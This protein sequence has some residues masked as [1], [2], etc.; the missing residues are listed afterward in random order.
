[1]GHVIKFIDKGVKLVVKQAKFNQQSIDLS[2][3]QVFK[4]FRKL[5]RTRSAARLGYK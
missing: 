1:M 5:S 3:D 4:G 2:A